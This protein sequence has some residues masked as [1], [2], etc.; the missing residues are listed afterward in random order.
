M[1]TGQ[2]LTV[3]RAILLIY[4]ATEAQ[5]WLQLFQWFQL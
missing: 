1:D 2:F 3:Y 5:Q 4:F